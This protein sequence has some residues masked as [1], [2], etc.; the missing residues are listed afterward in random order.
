M[1]KYFIVLNDIDHQWKVVDEHG[2]CLWSNIDY[3]DCLSGASRFLG[4]SKEMIV[5]A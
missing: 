1:S 5:D 2:Y 3:D 4:I